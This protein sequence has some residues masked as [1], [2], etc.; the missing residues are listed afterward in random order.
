MMVAAPGGAAGRADRR[1]CG[2]RGR[3]RG[4]E[5]RQDGDHRAADRRGDGA[6]APSRLVSSRRIA[7]DDVATSPH[8]TS[9]RLISSHVVTFNVHCAAAIAATSQCRPWLR[10]GAEAEAEADG[11]IVPGDE[12]RWLILCARVY[13]DSCLPFD[14]YQAS[15]SPGPV[16]RFCRARFVW[17]DI[18]R[19]YDI[20]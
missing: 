3:A 2:E 1:G 18:V 5:R 9:P 15:P 10:P 14:Q 11:T 8:L 16:I 20:T 13:Y 17:D 7:H 4:A 19:G 12:P 6:I